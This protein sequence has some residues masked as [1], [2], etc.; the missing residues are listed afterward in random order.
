[1]NA[2]TCV[3]PAAWQLA[4][5]P[6][7]AESFDRAA[8]LYARLRRAGWGATSAVLAAREYHGAAT[9]G[10]LLWALATQRRVEVRT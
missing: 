4:A 10:M 7:G 1:M 8:L 6:T 2:E 9:E 5:W 3:E